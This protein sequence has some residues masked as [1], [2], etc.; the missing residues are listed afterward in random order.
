MKKGKKKLMIIISSP[1]ILL[2]AVLITLFAI[3]GIFMPSDYLKPWS[4]AYQNRFEDPRLK[5][6]A[7][8]LL[9]AN[10]HNMQPWKIRLDKKDSSVFYL[11]ADSS[12]VT[13]EV[14]PLARQMMIS[15]GTFLE[16]V[17]IT[18]DEL[19]TPVTISLFPEGTYDEDHLYE[20][21]D[22]YPVAKITLSKAAPVKTMLYDA[23]FLPDTNRGDYQ[24][25]VLPLEDMSSLEDTKDF[26]GITANIRSNKSELAVLGDFAVKAA[27]IEANTSRVMTETEVI[28]RSNEYQ[29][30]K[31]RYGFSVEGQGTS[32]FMK[33]ILQGIVTIFPSMNSGKAQKDTFISSTK[34]SVA[35]TP[36]YLLLISKDNS[37]FSQVESGM[38]YSYCILKAHSMGLVMQPLS[39]V[40]EEYDEMKEVYADIQKQYGEGGTIQMLM[41]LGYPT[42]DAPRS[43][44]QD[45]TS[46]LM[47]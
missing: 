32:G 35:N 30:N 23:I 39:Q 11:Y 29:K 24:N 16:Y 18:G 10:G 3:S 43:M 33:H 27:Q 4:N 36:S 21:M 25:K 8:G 19:G 34:K 12:R 31:Y 5:L 7:C 42:S 14:D 44:R 47:K 38:A 1:I 26:D 45:V 37:R 40:L 41:R 15:Q 2:V 6:S 20:S 28:F 17:K 46:L 9:A 22:A 13:K